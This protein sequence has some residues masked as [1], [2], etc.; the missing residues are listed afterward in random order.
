[1]KHRNSYPKALTTAI[2]GAA[3]TTSVC[4]CL[5]AQALPI[6]ID[7]FTNPTSPNPLT[8]DGDNTATS[9]ETSINTGL[10]GTTDREAKIVGT[11]NG[12]TDTSTLFIGVAGGSG[13]F[14]T[15]SPNGSV[16]T[17]TSTLTYTD[18]SSNF[19]AAGNSQFEFSLTRSAP[20]SSP[21]IITFT[22]NGTSTF[23]TSI[24]TTNAP[25]TSTQTFLFG[26]FTDPNVFNN[27]IS[28]LVSVETKNSGYA[29]FRQ[30][31]AVPVP[32][33]LIGTLLMAGLAAAKKLQKK[34]ATL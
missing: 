2:A 6:L 12:N 24:P 15:T 20:P 31:R 10:G 4:L 17:A 14:T 18:F 34:S 22:V 21:I 19:I 11:N 5:P 7:G 16:R 23:T 3:L 28:L 30:L 27:V 26:S 13:S 1:M 33:A 25:V 8:V 29:T 9:V 32:P